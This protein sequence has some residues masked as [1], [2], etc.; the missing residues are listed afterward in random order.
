M[1]IKCLSNDGTA[2]P[3]S[4]LD[5]RAGISSDTVFPLTV[6][7][8]YAV[9]AFTVFLSHIWYYIINDDRLPWPV[10]APA[11]LFDVTDGTLPQGWV[12][13]YF[14]FANGDQYP[15]VSFPEWATDRR[16]YERL[17]DGGKPERELFLHWRQELE[18]D[19]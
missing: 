12:Y 10:W 6:G 16:F 13:G 14:R 19:R 9:Y 2:L 17:V 11:P 1:I 5:P 7:R 8:K 4:C 15:L 18:H 3:A